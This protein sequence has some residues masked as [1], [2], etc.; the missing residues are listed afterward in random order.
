[1]DKKIKATSIVQQVV[2]NEGLSAKMP[3]G[4]NVKIQSYVRNNRNVGI[5]LITRNGEGPSYKSTCIFCK[6]SSTKSEHCRN[7]IDWQF[8]NRCMTRNYMNRIEIYRRGGMMKPFSPNGC[9]KSK[10]NCTICQEYERWMN[11]NA[12]N[13][14]DENEDDGNNEDGGNDS[15]D[16]DNIE[17]LRVKRRRKSS[18]HIPFFP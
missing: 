12:N 2:E 4:S 18:H 14:E 9:E 8:C 3:D 6:K 5:S 16:N 10:A 17:I 15:N 7:T 1:M 11:A 13:N